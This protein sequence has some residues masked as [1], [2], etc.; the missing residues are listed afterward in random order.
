M[1]VVVVMCVRCFQLCGACVWERRCKGVCVA[2]SVH[3]CV[4]LCMVLRVLLFM[5]WC[6][7]LCVHLGVYVCAGVLDSVVCFCVHAVAS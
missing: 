6:A 5:S 7:L 3:M 2:L 1:C 4:I